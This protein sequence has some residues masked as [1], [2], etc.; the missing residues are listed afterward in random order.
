MVGGSGAMEAP[1]EKCDSN[2]GGTQR[3]FAQSCQACCEERACEK[4]SSSG[5]KI[6]KYI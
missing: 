5:T 6:P 1:E 4:R 3:D 2:V